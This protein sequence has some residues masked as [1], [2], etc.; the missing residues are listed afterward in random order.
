MVMSNSFVYKFLVKS[1]LCSDR[2]LSKYRFTTRPTYLVCQD[3]I[4]YNPVIKLCRDNSLI[5]KHSLIIEKRKLDDEKHTYFHSILLS[6]PQYNNIL[7][8]A[9]SPTLVKTVQFLMQK[10]NINLS[11]KVETY[12]APFKGLAIATLTRKRKL[13]SLPSWAILNLSSTNFDE[14]KLG[15]IMYT[16]WCLDNIDFLDPQNESCCI[17]NVE[18]FYNLPYKIIQTS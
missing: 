15:E 8:S 2:K 7:K 12:G 16:A 6:I 10:S 17:W 4:H 5:R 13:I 18:N 3:Y 14:N 11:L 1:N 9:L